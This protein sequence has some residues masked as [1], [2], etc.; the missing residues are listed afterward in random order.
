DVLSKHFFEKTRRRPV[1]LP[2]IQEIE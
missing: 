2:I 1:I